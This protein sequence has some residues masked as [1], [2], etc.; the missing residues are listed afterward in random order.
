MV[1]MEPV[2]TY[3]GRQVSLADV[4]FICE[5]I[6]REK[7]ASRRALSLKLC[8]AWGWRQEN[9]NPRDM[10]C[11]GLLLALQRAGHI[12]L[13]PPRWL[14]MHPQ[15]R[16]HLKPLTTVDVSDKAESVL[17][18]VNFLEEL[19]DVQNVYSNFDIPDELMEKLGG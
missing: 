18:L 16:H 1:G 9:G 15:V 14:P 12:E 11:R 2:L 4:A 10:V 7:P 3:R 17:R 13:P 8:E 19:D 6:G 5:L